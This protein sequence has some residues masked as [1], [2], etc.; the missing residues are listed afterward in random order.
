MNGVDNGTSFIDEC[1]KTVTANG[2]V[3]T[4]AGNF[5]FAPSSA[6]FGGS[7]GDFLSIP[8]SG[9]WNFGSDKFTIDT[10]FRLDDPTVDCQLIFKVHGSEA[11]KAFTFY[12]RCLS[13]TSSF[14]T[15][16]NNGSGESNV[17]LYYFSAK[18]SDSIVLRSS[19]WYHVA[20][21]RSG[22]DWS[23]YLDGVKLIN[24]DAAYDSSCTIPNFGYG[25]T[26]GD[27][28]KGY[29]DELRVSKGI[30][31]WTKNFTPPKRPYGTW[32]HEDIKPGRKQLLLPRSMEQS[33]LRG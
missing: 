2:N 29:I 25:V 9:D 32:Y 31:R 24:F 26:I 8:N 3:C 7:A 14:S 23:V 17:W 12:Y 21:T 10:Y 11:R 1:G 20:L 4:K 15:E 5:K 16:I 6:Y 30:A 27:Y 19:A 13:G 28:L 18:K 22:S 33:Y